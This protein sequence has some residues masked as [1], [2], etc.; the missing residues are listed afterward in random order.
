MQVCGGTLE[1]VVVV[2]VMLGFGR[3]IYVGNEKET[4]WMHMPAEEEDKVNKLDYSSYTSPSI[5]N[6]EQGV[7]AAEAVKMLSPYIHNHVFDTPS[8][9]KSPSPL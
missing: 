5:D 4:L 8:D 2:V 6:P 9:V 1:G 3:V 7:L